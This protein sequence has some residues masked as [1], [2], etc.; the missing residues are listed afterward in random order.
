MAPDVKLRMR[1]SGWRFVDYVERGEHV[2]ELIIK[3]T[4]VHLTVM[5]EW[6]GRALS[7]RRV[8]AVLG[9]LFE[10]HSFLTTRILTEHVEQ[11]AFITRLGFKKTWEDAMFR[12]YMLDALPFQRKPT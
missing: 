12:Y 10:T 1:Q 4:E 2:A 6:R 7:R 9:P 3:G 11:Q 5:P 8:L